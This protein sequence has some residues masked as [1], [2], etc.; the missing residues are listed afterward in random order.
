MIRAD[1]FNYRVRYVG[2]IDV[3]SCTMHGIG[4]CPC[5]DDCKD[6]VSVGEMW[7]LFMKRAH[8]GTVTGWLA[9]WAKSKF[10]NRNVE[11]DENKAK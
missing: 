2:S 10:D 11:G 6:Y 7:E 3:S 4:K 8:E 9:D 1:C 5:T